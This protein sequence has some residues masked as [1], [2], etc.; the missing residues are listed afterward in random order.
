MED[1]HSGVHAEEA[2]FQQ[3][4]PQYNKSLQY[5]VT[6]YTSSSPC[7]A[8]ATKLGEILQARKTLHLNIHCSRL[9]LWEEPEIQAG[10]KALA[11]AGCKL[12]MMRPVDF[13]YLCKDSSLKGHS[14]QLTARA[15]FICW[16]VVL[17]CPL[18]VQHR[19]TIMYLN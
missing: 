1:E 17:F 14:F 13:S 15:S 5:T 6:W 10:L 3:V 9:F 19:P 8:C 11:K 16:N 4:L 7:A 2:F 12:R 18:S